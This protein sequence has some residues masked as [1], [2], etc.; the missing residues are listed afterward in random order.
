MTLVQP[1]VGRPAGRRKVALVIGSGALKCAAAFGVAKVL[2]RE[3]IVID[4]VVGCSGGAFCAAWVAGGGSDADA[5]AERFAE[6]W[7]GAFDRVKYGAILSAFFPR[8]LRFT[9]HA[10]IVD[11]RRINAGIAH[12]AGD[13]TIEGRPVPLFLVATDL[14]SGEKVVLSTGRLFDAIR[15][16][17]ALPLV[18]PPWPVQGRLLVDG[19]VSDPLPIDVAIQQGADIILA[20]G[21]ENALA[22]KFDSAMG[23]V[24]QLQSTMM[25][26]LVRAQYAFYNLS[27]H[28]EVL[29][30]IPEFEHS[31][32]L[33]AVHRVP[34]LVACGEHAAE[35]Q[36]PY[37][38]R[39]M[40]ST[41]AA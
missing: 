27:H 24:M 20:V 30:I 3:G 8:L 39:L 14:V 40:A 36:V 22:P 28:A 35:L 12:Y 31:I 19:A 1:A 32:G 37:L 29:P 6:G 41:V 5:A 23:L 11:D 33:K 25:N 17:I 18:L 7:T 34:Y 13:A 9:E 15:A 2:Q 21:F 38:R 26:H 4:M 10:S 16:S